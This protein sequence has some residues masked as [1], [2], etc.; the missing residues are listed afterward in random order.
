MI[1]GPGLPAR[2]E[3][4]APMVRIKRWCRRCGART[5][6]AAAGLPRLRRGWAL[7]YPLARLVD[8]LIDPPA[9]LACPWRRAREPDRVGGR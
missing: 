8:R 9:C 4:A 3:G 1:A 6:H 5:L 7:F 2:T